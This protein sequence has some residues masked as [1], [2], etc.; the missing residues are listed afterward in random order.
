MITLLNYTYLAA[1]LLYASAF[2]LALLNLKKAE[3]WLGLMAL[4]SNAVA[5]MLIIISS[6]HLPVFNLFESFL[7][8]TFVL[9][10]LG[11][12]CS[13][14]DDSFPD[15]RMWVWMEIIIL[16]GIT[17]FFTKTPSLFLYDHDYLYIL[18]FFG[19]RVVALA[20]MLFSTAQF[21][22]FRVERKRGISKNG[23]LHKGRNFL[24]LS[25][26]IFIVA[27]YVGIIWCQNGWGDF[28]RWS[29]G[30][31]QSTLIV[32]YLMVAFHIP[33]RNYRAESIRSL[34][35][36]MSGFVMLTLIIIRSLPK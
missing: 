30:F 15:V 1:F 17:L 27:E 20:V 21:I 33:G 16:F 22:Q 34:I 8:V 23:R 4:T 32:L 9:G 35:G 19:F 25:A 10:A 18:L 14:P 26:I 24:V 29:E 11:I 28:W 31:F 5:L 36:S 2:A 12:F 6:G 7:L 3:K 13:K